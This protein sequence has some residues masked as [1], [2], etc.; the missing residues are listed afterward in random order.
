MARQRFATFGDY[1]RKLR[2]VRGWTQEEVERRSGGALSREYLSLL[3]SGK[4]KS[5]SPPICKVIARVYGASWKDVA[6]AVQSELFHERIDV[7]IKVPEGAAEV[8]AVY[9]G[10]NQR[11]RDWLLEQARLVSRDPKYT[12]S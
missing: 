12:K 2:E 3:E 11:G 10:L 4:R 6:G 8:I 9:D 1:L 7:E 5:P